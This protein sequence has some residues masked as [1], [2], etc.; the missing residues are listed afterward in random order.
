MYYIVVKEFSSVGALVYGSEDSKEID[1]IDNLLN[2][3]LDGGDKQ[4]VLLSNLEMW[5]E[6][7]PF[8]MIEDAEEF[9]EKAISE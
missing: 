9:I 2:S 1:R 6:Y 8:E 4:V 7:E 3:K 5:K